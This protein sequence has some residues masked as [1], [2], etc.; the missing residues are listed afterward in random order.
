MIPNLFFIR[1]DITKVLFG[2]LFD[3]FVKRPVFVIAGLVQGEDKQGLVSQ[4]CHRIVRISW[5][6]KFQKDVHLFVCVFAAWVHE[7]V[8]SKCNKNL[9]PSQSCQTCLRVCMV[10]SRRRHNL[11]WW[12]LFYGPLWETSAQRLLEL[13][14]QWLQ[15]RKGDSMST[16]DAIQQHYA[17]CAYGVD[18]REY[19][20][21]ATSAIS[22]R[23]WACARE[24]SPFSSRYLAIVMLLISAWYLWQTHNNNSKNLCMSTSCLSKWL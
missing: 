15:T 12:G 3:L 18:D 6:K 17:D 19:K 11:H 21:L 9:A 1:V 10:Q 8:W 24:E 22:A 2:P 23:A 16:S 5:N 13:K 4:L 14:S 7:C 20:L